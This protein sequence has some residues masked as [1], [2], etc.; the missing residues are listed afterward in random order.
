[1]QT[2]TI[3]K[4][5]SKPT[6]TKL[7]QTNRVGIQTL[8]YPNKWLN[9]F[10]NTVDIKAGD[11]IYAEITQNGDFLNFKMKGKQNTTNIPNQ[12]KP[13]STAQISPNTAIPQASKE[14]NWDKIR[15]EKTE[16]IAW[17]NAKNNACLLIAHGKYETGAE[18][19]DAIKELAQ[20]IYLLQ[21]N[22]LEEDKDG[23]LTTNQ[24]PF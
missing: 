10:M 14:V 13:A 4:V 5:T 22:K 6:E 3:L 16:N 2:L 23:N 7:G 24:I 9:S 15:E 1:M 21:P 17:M 11:V 19:V 20:E 18:I 8:E 12:P